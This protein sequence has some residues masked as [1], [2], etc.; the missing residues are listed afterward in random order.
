MKVKMCSVGFL[1]LVLGSLATS[2]SDAVKDVRIQQAV[3]A[4]EDARLCRT[5]V[6]NEANAKLWDERI[7]LSEQELENVRQ[8]VS[9]EQREHSLTRKSKASV[10][11]TLQEKLSELLI[12]RTEVETRLESLGNDLKRLKRQYVDLQNQS[13]PPDAEDK[14]AW[15]VERD[16]K[17]SAIEAR[18]KA[19]S[20]QR[21]L[22]DLELRMADEVDRVR[23]FK[24]NVEYLP[25]PTTRLLWSTRSELNQVRRKLMDLKLVEQD[26]MHQSELVAQT[27]ALAKN[28]R[29]YIEQDVELLEQRFL[30][31]NRRRVEKEQRKEQDEITR[32]I[33]RMLVRTREQARYMEERKEAISDELESLKNGLAL[34]RSGM[35]LLD[36]EV[37]FREQDY[38]QLKRRYMRHAFVPVFIG[39]LI[40]LL[41][42]GLNRMV[43]P[44]LYKGDALFVARRLCSYTSFFLVALV[45]V[46]AFFEDLKAIATVMGLVGAAIVIALQ[47][48]CSSFAG[49]FVIVA[50]RKVRVGQRVEIDGLRGDVVDI[51]ILRT[52][53]LELNNWLGVDEP[54]GRIVIIPNSFI[55]KSKV[56]NYSHVHPFIWGKVDVCVTFETPT[57]EAQQLLERI[58][59]EETVEEFAS[60]N[61]AVQNMEKAYAHV[62][63]VNRPKVNTFIADS[64]ITFTLFYVTHYRRVNVTRNKLNRRIIKEFEADPRMEFAYPT[65]RMIPTPD[66]D[67]P[68][69][70]A[71]E[72]PHV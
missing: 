15:G 35:D 55:F 3:E 60:A 24:N 6:T 11:Y 8:L 19:S 20:R 52:T 4:L 21:E 61:R 68:W 53:L 50:S 22:A 46:S 43:W 2:Y 40:I 69:N 34:V 10:A 17:L 12:D 63:M 18:I 7:S 23:D 67:R 71:S 59:E 13:A 66:P 48:L 47:D 28:R 31:E 54:T 72:Q 30:V 16:V 70:P 27:G 32:R 56:F 36:A 33:K 64:G 29:A 49:W 45:L 44:K 5:A 41:S 39:F 65:E 38:Q 51:Q 26:L 57:E 1:L 9:I 58:L 62:R 37:Q 42:T 14:E 25:R